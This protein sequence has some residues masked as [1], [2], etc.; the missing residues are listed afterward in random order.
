VS[1]AVIASASASL[2]GSSKGGITL[3]KFAQM[4]DAVRRVQR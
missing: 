3:P 1:P 2:F 4:M